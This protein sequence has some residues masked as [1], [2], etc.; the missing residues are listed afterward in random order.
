MKSIVDELGSLRELGDG[1]CYG[2][3]VRIPDDTIKS[4]QEIISKCT[5]SGIL[6]DYLEVFPG[7]SGEV[8]IG[9]PT[10]KSYIAL[11]IKADVIECVVDLNDIEC[12]SLGNISVDDISEIIAGYS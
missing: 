3:G 2:D 5:A 10:A 4:A 9:V 11:I 6:P 12:V 7:L 1:W 8:V